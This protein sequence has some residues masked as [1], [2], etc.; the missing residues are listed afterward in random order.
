MI[1]PS[2]D[3]NITRIYDRNM[4]NIK[5]IWWKQ[6]ERNMKE[7]WLKYYR[8]MTNIWQI[9]D[10]YMT[11]MWQN[12]DY[13]WN[14]TGMWEINDKNMNWTWNMLTT[15]QQEYDRNTTRI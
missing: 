8:N 9:Y 12:Q 5:W 14:I 7:I 4:T 11:V 2:T 15:I 3:Q 6:Y 10:K 13:D 1:V